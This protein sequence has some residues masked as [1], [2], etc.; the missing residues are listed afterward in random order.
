MFRP[1]FYVACSLSLLCSASS[2]GVAENVFQIEH[3]PVALKKAPKKLN[4]V[5]FLG[6]DTEPVPDFERRLSELMLYLQQYYGREMQ[7]NGY[8]PRSF[9]LDMKS[10]DRVNIIVYK[11]KEPASA[12]P[13]ENGGGYKALKELQ[14]FYKA[15]PDKKKSGHNLII[16]PTWKDGKNTDLNPGG[17]PFYGIGRDCFALD[18]PAFDLKHLGQKTT[19]GRLLTKWYGGLAHELGHGLNLPHNHATT[20]DEKK[21]G[22]ALM[23][24]GNYTFG[25]TPTY[26][27]PASAAI[28]DVC[29]VFATDP[30]KKYYEGDSAVQLKGVSITFKGDE[31]GI[32][33]RYSC[34]Q[35]VR[36]LNVYV[37][38][39]PYAVNQDYDAVSF[40]FPLKKKKGEFAV[41]IDRKELAG[42]SGNTFQV[43]LTFL[44]DNGHK[45]EKAVEFKKDDLKDYTETP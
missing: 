30:A 19:E 3:P 9:G 4:V 37:Q 1:V 41:K 20:T 43:K 14:E 40:S 13:Y 23:G 2:Q 27:T 34:S 18:Y 29:E 22:T 8:G 15:H 12:Y 6:N 5:Y 25:M 28:L 24:S 39:A 17:V 32:S 26:L 45:F 44:L 21:L 36:A 16:M 7:R 35:V 33:G 31:I 10:K 11:A 42:L 38:D